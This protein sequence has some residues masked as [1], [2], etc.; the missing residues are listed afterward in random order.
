MKFEE[1]LM[2]FYIMKKNL[3]KTL[4][5]NCF[6]CYIEKVIKHNYIINNDLYR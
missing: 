2:K 1:N 5:S 3:H 6:S 4:D